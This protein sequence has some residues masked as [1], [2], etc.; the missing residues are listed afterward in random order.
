AGR[1]LA[2]DGLAGAAATRARRRRV[3]RAVRRAVADRLRRRRDHRARGP[4]LREDRR[5]DQARLPDRPRRAEAVHQV[6]AA[7]TVD[8][9]TERDIAKAIDHSLLRPELDDEFVDAGCRLA[10]EY[11]V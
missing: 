11:D 8:S 4:R 6:S 7:L 9:L 5:P 1:L 2:G 3:G 10:R